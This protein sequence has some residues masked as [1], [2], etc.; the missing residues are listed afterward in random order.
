VVEAEQ[1]AAGLRRAGC[2]EQ[3]RQDQDDES[4][5]YGGYRRSRASARAMLVYA[6]V[7]AAHGPAN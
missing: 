7:A 1:A 4:C 5:F 6:R 3:Q 2:A